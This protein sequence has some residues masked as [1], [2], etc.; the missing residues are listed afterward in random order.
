[1][2]LDLSATATN[3]L[4]T[5][6]AASES[7]YLKL[8]RRAAGTEDPDT[9]IVTPGTPSELPVNGA[10]VGYREAEVDGN[11]IVKGDKK[12]VIDNLVQPLPS[13]VFIAGGKRFTIIAI[14]PVNHAGVVQVYHCQLRST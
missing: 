8:E 3:L 11:R 7:G 10:L 5:L 1:M 12:A 14:E 13:D 9:G 2:A 6:A 4:R